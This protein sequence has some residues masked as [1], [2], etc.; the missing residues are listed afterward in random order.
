MTQILVQTTGFELTQALQNACQETGNKVAQRGARIE[1]V[2]FF[3]DSEGKRDGR[4][5]IAKIK[6]KRVGNDVFVEEKGADM[7]QVIRAVGKKA[8]LAVNELDN[9]EKEVN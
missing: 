4:V 2:E 5:F 3:L 7:Y 8:Q 6:V 9:A 1:K